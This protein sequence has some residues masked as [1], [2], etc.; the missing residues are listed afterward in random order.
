MA[1]NRALEHGPV[2][3]HRVTT[4]VQRIN[5]LTG[6]NYDAGVCSRIT[7]T[8]NLSRPTYSTTQ[9]LGGTE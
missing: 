1:S 2:N 7:N 6:R 3:S 4:R 9:K 8:G 5:T